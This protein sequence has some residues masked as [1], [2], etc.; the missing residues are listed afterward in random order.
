MKYGLLPSKDIETIEKTL[1][2]ACEF[3]GVLNTLEIGVFHGDTSRGIRDYLKNKGREI[4]HTAID[5]QR[6]FKMN[7]PFPE[8][9]F[10]IGNSYEVYTKVEPDKHFIFI[11]GNHSFPITM[12]DFLVYESKVVDGGYIAFHDTGKQIKPF[13]DF[14]GIGDMADEDMYIACRKAVGHLGLLTNNYRGW[15][16]VF[17]EYDENFH[18]GGVLVIRKK[19]DYSELFHS[20]FDMP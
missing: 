11:D 4:S 15:E 9:K 13:T 2:L 14:Q 3:K 8:C 16:L 10:L 20:Y 7:S 19:K 1:D 6:D 5:N 18:T 12:V 17:D